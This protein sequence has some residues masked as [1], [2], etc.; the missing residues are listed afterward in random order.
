MR[1]LPGLV[2]WLV[3]HPA[4][5]LDFDGI[6]TRVSDG[7]TVWVRP[8]DPSRRPVKI[9]LAGLD[10]PERCQPWGREAGDA[11]SARVLH[12]HVQVATR[13]RDSYGRFVAVLRLGDEDVG[14]WLVAQGH[15]WN[16]GYKRHRGRYAA[17]EQAARTARRGLFADAQAIEPRDFRHT[18]GRCR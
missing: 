10:A 15:A 7:D 16:Q 9:R 13:A 5:A 11:L 17:Q 1:T 12:R 6:V 18:H 4:L 3:V 8:D 14:A 2:L